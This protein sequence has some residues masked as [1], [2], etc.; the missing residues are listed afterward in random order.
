[1]F[2]MNAISMATININGIT[3]HARAGML[4][5]LIRHHDFDIIFVQEVMSPGVLNIRGYE[6]HLNIRTSMRGTT[7][8]T[9]SQHPN[10]NVFT[11]P[12]GR[13]ITANF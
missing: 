11:I 9:K 1:M 12:P 7:I 8:I 10:T 3:A 5:E 4:A 2:E 13:A 6:T